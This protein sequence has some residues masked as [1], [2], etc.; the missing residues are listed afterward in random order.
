MVQ[1]VKD[2]V[3]S[4]RRPRN[5]HM[6]WAWPKTVTTNQTKCNNQSTYIYTNLNG[7]FTTKEI[8]LKEELES[9]KT[10]LKK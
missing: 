7:S 9:W 8:K 2:P 1:R 5:F 4:L 3:L 10:G 6:L